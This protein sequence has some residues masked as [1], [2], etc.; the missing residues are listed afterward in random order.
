M[1]F[2]LQGGG[3][4][5]DVHAAACWAEASNLVAFALPDHYLLSL[6]PEVRTDAPDAFAQ[7]AALAQTTDTIELVVLVAPITFRHP[8]VMGKLAA[9]IDGLS[10]G[11]FHLGVG[12]GW[13]EREHEVFGLPFPDRAVRFDMLEEALG[14]LR[15]M[16]AAEP[17]AFR[18]QYYSLE[19]ARI[20][21]APVGKM[22][23]VVGGTGAVKTPRLAG[24]YADEFNVY[25]GRDAADR[26]TRA[27]QAAVDAGRD[28][29][30]ILISSAGAVLVAETEADYRDLFAARAAEAGLE[31]EALETHFAHRNTPRGSADQVQSTLAELA[32]AGVSRFYLQI[33]GTFDSA[34]V[35]NTLRLMGALT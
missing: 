6:N 28:P 30:A 22:R 13:L 3:A 7:F 2:A 4:W 25:P 21:P 29:D 24:T 9:T 26:V 8:A 33:G 18:G 34:D 31:P 11:R 23:L 27:K 15:A 1:K 10:G 14:Y 20:D 12:T 32:V 19:A 16:F 35:R 5:Q 17:T